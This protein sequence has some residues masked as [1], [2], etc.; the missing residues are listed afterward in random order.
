MPSREL[1]RFYFSHIR[2]NDLLPSGHVLPQT[3][4][5][6]KLIQDMIRTTHLTKFHYDPMINVAPR[7]LK[8][9]MLTTHGAQQMTH[10]RR[11]VIPKTQQEQV[12]FSRAIKINCNTQQ[13]GQT[14]HLKEDSTFYR[15]NHA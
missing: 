12:V 5:I 7:V 13:S 4:T 1:T 6:F 3:E 2:K 10:D 15:E 8:R 9:Q 14:F 11:K